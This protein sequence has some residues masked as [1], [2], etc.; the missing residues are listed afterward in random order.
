MIDLSKMVDLEKE[1]GAQDKKSHWE[2]VETS[3]K[4]VPG[5]IAHHT[6][7]TFGDKMFLFGGSSSAKENM[8]MFQLDLKTFRWEVLNG[9]NFHFNSREVKCQCSETNT[10]PSFMT[11][12]WSFLGDSSMENT[13][14]K[15]IGITLK[16]TSG[17]RCKS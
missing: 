7:V 6:S 15:F 5:A 14:T 11:I 16:K 4:E 8:D 13:P 17:K 10:Q 2:L 3:G 12:Q 1:A 9:V